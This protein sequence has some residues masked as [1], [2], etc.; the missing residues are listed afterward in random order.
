MSPTTYFITGANRG[1]GFE[2]AKQLLEANPEARVIAGAR[3]PEKADALQALVQASGGRAA[4]ITL[5]LVSLQLW[6]L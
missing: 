6:C 1:I 2:F 5:D 3:A 4:V